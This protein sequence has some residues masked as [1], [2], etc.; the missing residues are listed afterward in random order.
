MNRTIW[1]L[2]LQGWDDTPYLID[3]VRQTW[4]HNNPGWR[5][6][7]IS[8]DNLA[9]YIDVSKIPW[10]A[11]QAA[12]SDVIRIHLLEKYGGVW[13]DSTLVCVNPLDSWIDESFKSIWMYRGGLFFTDPIGPAS[14]F[15]MAKEGSYSIRKWKEKVDEYWSTRE[16]T[17]NY[18]WLD[19]L[20][21]DLYKSDKQ[22]AE[23]WDSFKSPSVNLP[24]G[25][26]MMDG[27][28]NGVSKAV[29][30]TF[31]KHLP[32]IVKLNRRDYDETTQETNGNLVLRK[33]LGLL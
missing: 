30:D 4:V 7:L 2:W 6:Q 1:L 16:D 20:W 13:A 17:S 14:W 19:G 25:P 12:Q 9:D 22:F 26:A 29:Q 3:K 5:V 8:R 32:N 10:S 21:W 15:I 24:E 11:S 23:E 27:K 33:S 31:L 28:Y 18:F